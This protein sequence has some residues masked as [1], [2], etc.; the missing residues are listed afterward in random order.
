MVEANQQ[1][2]KLE[3][4]FEEHTRSGE[5]PNDPKDFRPFIRALLA[6]DLRTTFI[7]GATAVNLMILKPEL[8]ARREREEEK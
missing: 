7:D 5:S 1:K 8:L 4:I 2:S 3:K 6:G